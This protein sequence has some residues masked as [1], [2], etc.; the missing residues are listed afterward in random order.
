MFFLAKADPMATSSKGMGYN[1]T[2]CQKEEIQKYLVNNL[3]K[4]Q[5]IFNLPK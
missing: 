4:T 1:P 2:I 5:P 3:I